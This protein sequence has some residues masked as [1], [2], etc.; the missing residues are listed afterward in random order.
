MAYEDIQ[1]LVEGYRWFESTNKEE[2]NFFSSAIH[3]FLN[4]TVD[5]KNVLVLNE[6]KIKKI[7]E[8]IEK[9]NGKFTLFHNTEEIKFQFIDYEYVEGEPIT[10]G[11]KSVASDI[12]MCFGNTQRCKWLIKIMHKK[13]PVWYGVVKPENIDYQHGNMTVNVTA[14]GIEAEF[15]EYYQNKTLREDISYTYSN[16]NASYTYYDGRTH[17]PDISMVYYPLQTVM[18][19]NFPLGQIDF[20]I[21]T[22]LVGEWF[23]NEYPLFVQK[24][25]FVQGTLY[26]F[27]LVK[28]GYRKLIQEGVSR[29]SWLAKTCNAMGWQFFFQFIGS[30]LILFVVPRSRNNLSYIEHLDYEQINPNW[31]CGKKGTKEKF[32]YIEIPCGGLT[33]GDEMFFE[34]DETNPNDLKGNHITILSDKVGFVNRSIHFD[35]VNVGG[36][37][38]ASGGYAFLKYNGEDD[39]NYKAVAWTSD[40]PDYKTSTPTYYE[41]S[42]SNL[43]RLDSGIN[44]YKYIKIEGFGVHHDMEDGF[45]VGDNDLVVKGCY[46]DLLFKIPASGTFY[47]YQDYVLS[48]EFRLNFVPYLAQD[49][50]LEVNFSIN[51]THSNPYTTLRIDEATGEG[52][53]V[54]KGKYFATSEIETDYLNDITTYSVFET[55]I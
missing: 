49:K 52:E 18:S 43:L 53:Q 14:Y 33:G 21:N 35:F 50:E 6:L 19:D 45:A 51:E 17:Y 39:N 23:V 54:F 29:L 32:S 34:S 27:L 38:G 44:N 42:K 12:F 55:T 28:G 16:G 20:A 48:D 5:M 40:T 10:T 26:D 24:N 31:T 46:G 2:H 9:E 3:M 37:Q 11:T 7:F 25:D 36:H 30:T 1:I 8:N 47:T 4:S 41:I 22:N 15:G 13:L